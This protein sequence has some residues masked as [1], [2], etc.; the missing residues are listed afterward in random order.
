MAS[1]TSSPRVICAWAAAMAEPG[2]AALPPEARN[3]SPVES[4]LFAL[5]L[6]GIGAF[7]LVRMNGTPAAT[8]AA[9][10]E[11]KKTLPTQPEP[12]PKNSF[13]DIDTLLPDGTEAV[14]MI[15][16]KPYWDKIAA[17]WK[18]GSRQ[19]RAVEF[20]TAKFHFDPRKFERAV[21][22]FQ[23]D[24]TK[25]VASGEGAWLTPVWIA[26]LEKGRRTKVEPAD[27]RGTQTVKFFEPLPARE[28]PTGGAILKGQAYVI[29]D[30]PALESLTFRLKTGDELTDVDP[31]LLAPVREAA[32]GTSILAFAATAGWQLPTKPGAR[33][34]LLGTHGVDLIAVT[35]RLDRDFHFDVVLVGR[36]DK[37]LKEFLAVVLPKLLD[38][39][40]EKLAPLADAIRKASDETKVELDSVRGYRLKATVT[41]KWDEVIAALEVLLPSLVP[42]RKD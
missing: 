4:G 38:A 16:P 35:G 24:P 10:T 2:A 13:R 37:P 1:V 20:F 39:R 14:L 6:L 12:P 8:A 31:L 27:N 3:T 15:H 5:L 23:A 29:G 40:G 21:V 25:T 30:K 41:W 26:S 28:H 22:A 33:V 7:A 34:E 32:K 9:P 36:D 42:D 17:E 18:A 11:P 19:A